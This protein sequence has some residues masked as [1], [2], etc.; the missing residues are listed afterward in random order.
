MPLANLKGFVLVKMK[1]IRGKMISPWISKP[2]VTVTMYIANWVRIC[3]KHQKRPNVK[4]NRSL[5]SFIIMHLIKLNINNKLRITHYKWSHHLEFIL[6]ISSSSMLSFP[7]T[8]FTNLSFRISL[9]TIDNLTIRLRSPS[10]ASPV[11]HIW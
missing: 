11:A 4:F 8:S 7:Y 6:W 1:Y 3:N 5:F 2:D 9:Y 10:P